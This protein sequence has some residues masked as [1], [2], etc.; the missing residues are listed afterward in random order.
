MSMK[1]RPRRPKKGFG[2]FRKLLWG[3]PVVGTSAVA[4]F[5][6]AV[7]AIYGH[8]WLLA[9]TL[10]F[11]ALLLL[12]CKALTWKETKNLTYTRTTRAAVV[13]TALVL[14]G[15]SFLWAYDR[16]EHS[17]LAFHVLGENVSFNS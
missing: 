6:V 3:W 11:V 10:E 13:L 7:N 5:S 16:R 12:T 15:L 8:D 17:K 9:F 14:L 4:L 2:R 1:Q